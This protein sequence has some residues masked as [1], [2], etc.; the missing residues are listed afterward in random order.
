MAS[1]GLALE[2]HDFQ[3][4]PAG[5]HSYVGEIGEEKLKMKMQDDEVKMEM[6]AEFCGSSE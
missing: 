2:M 1:P 5:A 3:I 4:C 6:H